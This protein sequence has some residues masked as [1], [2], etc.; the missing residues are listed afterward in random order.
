MALAK[1][2]VAPGKT[3]II[4]AALQL[5]MQTRSIRALG[6]REIGRE[7]GLNPNT[8]YRHFSSMDDLGL[9][10]LDEVVAELRQPMR[11]LRRQAAA[12]VAGDIPAVRVPAEYWTTSLKKTKLVV[13]ETIRRYF[14]F[15]L[16]NPE[17][18]TIGVSELNGSSPALRQALHTV[19]ADFADDLAEDMRIL[20]LLPML[21]DQVV[22]DM[23]MTIIR[24]LFTL[25]TDYIET[26]QK[27]REM[28]ELAYAFIIS[29]TAGAIALEVRDKETL[30]D[31]LAVLRADD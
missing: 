7:A 15:V 2:A 31:L 26:D 6:V 25:S 12:S 16:A 17:A 1:P 30:A 21:S 4:Q 14:E 9:A 22:H 3:R 11:D 23:S 29:L 5:A 28:G 27:R 20:Q 8:F 18:F 19:L 10:I 13:H 24:Q